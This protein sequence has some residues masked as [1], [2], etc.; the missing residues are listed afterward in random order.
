M[1]KD[2][3]VD[4]KGAGMQLVAQKT[5]LPTERC[6]APRT[7]SSS[8]LVVRI[9]RQR[10]LMRQATVVDAGQ[11]FAAHFTRQN[12][13]LFDH[14]MRISVLAERLNAVLLHDILPATDSVASFH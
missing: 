6:V 2:I 9:T 7:K 3:V 8:S 10:S 11:Q 1:P 4:L 5:T 13:G 14:Q 12:H